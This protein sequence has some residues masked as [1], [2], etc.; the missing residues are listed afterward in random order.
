MSEYMI[1]TTGLTRL[2]GQTRALDDVS[3]KVRRGE[4][5]GFLGPNGAGKTTAMR[6]LAGLLAPTEGLV[7]V[8]GIDVIEDPVAARSH[9]GFLPETPPIYNDMT[10]REYL[11]YLVALRLVPPAQRKGAVERALE[12]CGLTQVSNRLLR[13][14]SK[15]YRQ[16]AGIAQAIAHNPDVVILDEP[17]VGLDPIQIREI[18]GLIREL[19]GEH[20]VLLSTHILPEVR[21]TCD[22]V[23]VINQGRILVED[24]LDGL[25]RRATQKQ[26]WR[27]RLAGKAQQADLMAIEGISDVTK[28]GDDWLIQPET[29]AD[30][31][32]GLV[33][34]AADGAWDLRELSPAGQSLE[35]IFVQLTTDEETPVAGNKTAPEAKE[36]A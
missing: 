9:I 24:S 11:A 31:L 10:V 1:E 33:R 35:D 5:M 8:A 2:F 6:V 14:L 30:P 26:G 32:P 20:S 12:M 18:R 28:E 34:A 29:D 27:V 16:R 36:V 25:E 15:G 19:G 21:M 23:T 13:N 22:R 3:I 17:T 4:V 7:K